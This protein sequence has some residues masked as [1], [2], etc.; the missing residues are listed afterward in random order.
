MAATPP[1]VPLI[2]LLAADPKC[3]VLFSCRDCMLCFMLPIAQVVRGLQARGDGDAST[4]VRA[5]ARF[6]RKP[7][8]RCGG[9]RFET[10]PAYSPRS[11]WADERPD[12]ASPQDRPGRPVADR[13]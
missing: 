10:R 12:G 4:G 2:D 6:T 7:C 9:R 13:G 1:G 5:V 3:R 11:G 8:A